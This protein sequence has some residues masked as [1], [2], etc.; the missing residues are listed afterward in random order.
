MKLSEA[1]LLRAISIVYRLTGITVP[2]R[3]HAFLQGRLRQRL[4]ALG[5]EDYTHYMDLVDSRRCPASETSAFVDAVTTN[6][7]S[8][9]RAGQ[10]WSYLYDRFLPSWFASDPGRPLSIWCGAASS[11][12]EV[13]TVGI[14]CEEFRRKNAGFEW[15]MLATD[16]SEGILGQARAGSYDG[17]AMQVSNAP[18]CFDTSRYFNSSE[19]RLTV[20]RRL[21][22]PITFKQHNLFN[23]APK[24][25]FDLVF[26]RNVLIYFSVEDT[27]RALRN[28][29]KP[30]RDGGLIFLGETETLVGVNNSL[31][32][33]APSI[34]AKN[35]AD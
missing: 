18:M 9:F 19:G 35:P 7:T 25:R 34:Y 21:A 15:R 1:E 30:L 26:L 33:V 5:L 13:Y 6:M 8:F 22:E 4:R 28:A 27:E 10:A 17:K 3:K 20:H 29:T 14:L 2:V 23:P 32:Y 31:N 12:Q 11:G 16:I 24:G